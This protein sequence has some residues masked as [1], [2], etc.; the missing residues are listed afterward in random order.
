MSSYNIKQAAYIMSLLLG[1]F[2]FEINEN[3]SRQI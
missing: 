1:T 2:D 3:H